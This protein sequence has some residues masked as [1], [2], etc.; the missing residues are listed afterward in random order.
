MAQ[1]VSGAVIP[2]IGEAL[3]L[4][5]QLVKWIDQDRCCA[6]TIANVSQKKLVHPKRYTESGSVREMPLEIPHD[7]T[8]LVAAQKTSGAATGS[9]GVLTYN[10]EPDGKKLQIMWSVPFDYNLYENWVNVSYGDEEASADLYN[11]LYYNDSDVTKAK[12][13]SKIF[14]LEGSLKAEVFMGDNGQASLTVKL[15][16]Q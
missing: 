11:H 9:V 2:G 4:A 10:L 16:W 7:T 15:F 6:I 3:G 14:D 12:D 13:T 8:G 5:D 1:V